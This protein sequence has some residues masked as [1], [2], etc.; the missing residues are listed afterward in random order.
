ML[1]LFGT[2][3]D[4]SVEQKLQSE[5]F[6]SNEYTKLINSTSVLVMGKMNLRRDSNLR[7]PILVGIRIFEFQSLSQCGKAFYSS[8]QQGERRELVKAGIR[9]HSVLLLV[10]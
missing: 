8:L 4:L 7:I 1:I 9:G 3:F 2:R 6:H 5:F 10:I